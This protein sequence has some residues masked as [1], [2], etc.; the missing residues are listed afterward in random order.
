MQY[1]YNGYTLPGTS[2]EIVH[3]DMAK[4]QT[5]NYT[6]YR[7]KT[8]DPEAGI[9]ARFVEAHRDLVV[10]EVRRPAYTSTRSSHVRLGGVAISNH[11]AC[12]QTFSGNL[13]HRAQLSSLRLTGKRSRSRLEQGGT[14]SSR[15]T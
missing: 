7:F 1:K 8:A 13:K 10:G 2:L 11:S 14:F 5:C 9:E 3:V 4:K 12:L 15:K 6:I